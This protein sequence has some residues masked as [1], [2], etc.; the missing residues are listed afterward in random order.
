MSKR[1]RQRRYRASA[2]RFELG[3]GQ[4]ARLRDFNQRGLAFE[5]SRALAV[6]ERV[7]GVLTRGSSRVEIAGKVCWSEPQPGAAEEGPPPVYRVGLE[8]ED[9]LPREIRKGLT[10]LLAGTGFWR[11]E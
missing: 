2:I 9:E 8:F 6:G 4:L 5:T 10:V 3:D 7:L 1:Q 11:P